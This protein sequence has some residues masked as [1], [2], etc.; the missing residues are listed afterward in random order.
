[1]WVTKP[2]KFRIRWFKKFRPPVLSYRFTPE[3]LAFLSFGEKACPAC[4][5]A[6]EKRRLCDI[7]PG[8]TSESRPVKRYSYAFVCRACGRSYGL[9]ELMAILSKRY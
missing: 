9:D 5:S 1:M 2:P 3:Q 4:G 8:M 7:E 6:L